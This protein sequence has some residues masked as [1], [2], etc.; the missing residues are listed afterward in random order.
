MGNDEKVNE[1]GIDHTGST[2]DWVVTVLKESCPALTQLLLGAAQ[3][4]HRRVSC[5]GCPFLRKVDSA[6]TDLIE[7][8]EV[9]DT[10][11]QMPQ[12]TRQQSFRG[13]GGDA[14]YPPM[15]LT[16]D[17]RVRGDIIHPPQGGGD[18]HQLMPGIHHPGSDI[19]A[20]KTY[21][22]CA[23]L[24][25]QNKGLLSNDLGTVVSLKP[26]CRYA[27]WQ[28]EA[29]KELVVWLRIANFK[30]VLFDVEERSDVGS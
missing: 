20:I 7:T 21:D 4:T 26:I 11:G 1:P 17:R 28:H 10:S 22:H 27:D 30:G 19:P 2:V 8:Q 14:E 3:A 18:Y 16:T 6:R 15:Q 5:E 23:M 12:T 29:R 13:N 9:L 25:G 24:E